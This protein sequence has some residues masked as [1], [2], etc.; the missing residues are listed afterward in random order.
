VFFF[1][2]YCSG[3]KGILKF[4]GQWH[5]GS[6][7][8]LQLQ[9][10]LQ[11][12]QQPETRRKNLTIAESITN[13][14]SSSNTSSASNVVDEVSNRII[15]VAEF[16]S[17]ESSSFDLTSST[18]ASASASVV[19]ELIE[20]STSHNI[21]R[22]FNRNN[23]DIT[24]VLRT[25]LDYYESFFKNPCLQLKLDILK[26]MLYLANSVFDSRQQYES[27][28]SKLQINFEWLNSFI[29]QDSDSQGVKIK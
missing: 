9:Q 11:Q 3:K 18:A 20:T 8:H 2:I 24:S 23:L 4:L 10:Q 6:L 16:L 21:Q 15:K 14:V 13:L 22:S 1:K 5:N 29:Q 27:L 19:S 12:Q 17:D 28:M 7:E 25:V 26:S